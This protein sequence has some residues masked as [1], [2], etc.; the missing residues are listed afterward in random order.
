MC[1]GYHHLADKG[2]QLQ[3]FWHEAILQA[4]GIVR[5]LE[6]NCHNMGW[7]CLE[8]DCYQM[9]RRI[10]SKVDVHD[11][12]TEKNL[13]TPQ[14]PPQ[15]KVNPLTPDA[16]QQTLESPS[17]RSLTPPH[18]RPWAEPIRRLRAHGQNLQNSNPTRWNSLFS[19]SIQCSWFTFLS[20]HWNEVNA[21]VGCWLWSEVPWPPT[22]FS[23]NCPAQLVLESQLGLEAMRPE[24]TLH[25]CPVK[26]IDKNVYTLGA[27]NWFPDTISAFEFL[28]IESRKKHD[29][30]Q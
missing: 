7:K 17:T 29:T 23:K 18:P 2:K 22:N 26:M 9:S 30:P 4:L 13:A 5:P 3:T 12:L 1:T 27:M 6:M 10:F 25:H 24:I 16:Q 14:I 8:L 11:L 21:K 19:P 28:A 15:P 20:L